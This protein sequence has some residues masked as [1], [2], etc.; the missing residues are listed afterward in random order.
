M[1][2]STRWP[3]PH[4]S[5]D[6]YQPGPIYFVS[7]CCILFLALVACSSGGETGSRTGSS[8][9]KATVVVSSTAGTTPKILFGA[10][11]CPPA[12]SLPGYWDP[13]IPT[14][15]GI[16]KVESVTC[17]N[18]I[19]QP[20]LQALVTVRTQGTG[21]LLDVYVY[22]QITSPAPARIFTLQGLYKGSARISHYN[23]LLTAEVDQ[24]SS[25]NAGKPDDELQVDLFREFQ[26][27]EGA[28]MLIPVAFPGI[29]PDLTRYQAENDQQQVNRGLDSWKLDAA[30]V[31]NALAVNLL[32]WPNNAST[33][34][35]SG[36]GQHD[37]NAVI[38]VK[39][40]NP[41]GGSIRVTLSRLEGNINGGIWIALS[42][43]SPG[44]SITAPPSRDL[45]VSP[46]TVTG[47]G[48]AFEGK[49]GRVVVLNHLY[50]N[51][52]Q[53]DAMGA[54]GNGNTSFSTQV[55][56]HTTFKRGSQEG[57]LALYSYSNA[58]GSIAA[59]VMLKE[60]LSA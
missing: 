50:D 30:K 29:F 7:L 21:A 17:A 19:G 43:T 2:L 40:S 25:I 9:T 28:G 26:W 37:A 51:V 23:T 42:V 16:N 41:G 14:E 47:T 52:G 20:A 11:P 10:Q 34:I 54:I 18:L 4:A 6:V 39:S 35:I 48:N 31:A 59:A 15:V 22:N 36:G 49:V 58:D 5:K 1:K 46:A 38:D 3:Y 60:M 8:T 57:I 27:S 53:A 32:H 24:N 56:Y 13:I 44:M 33:T 12:V 55:S 45:L